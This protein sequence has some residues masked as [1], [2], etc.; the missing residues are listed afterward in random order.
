MWTLLVFTPSALVSVYPPLY[1]SVLKPL[2]TPSGPILPYTQS[3]SSSNLSRS[4]SLCPVLCLSVSVR[5]CVSL[6]L[7]LSISLSPSAYPALSLS[8]S[9]F[10]LSVCLRLCLCLSLTLT[11]LT[12]MLS[13]WLIAGLLRACLFEAISFLFN[14]VKMFSKLVCVKTTYRHQQ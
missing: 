2:L 4:V 9:Q 10:A 8:L 13:S 3:P 12:T 6:Y 1:F 14:L 5:V 11:I 7:V